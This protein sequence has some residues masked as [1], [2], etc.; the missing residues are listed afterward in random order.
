MEEKIKNDLKRF[1]R[2][3]LK[4]AIVFG[5]IISVLTLADSNG[6]IRKYLAGF[7]IVAMSL[8]GAMNVGDVG[9]NQ[10]TVLNLEEDLIKVVRV[11][12]GDTIVV[13]PD[14][15]VRLLGIDAPEIGECFYQESREI[16]TE[17]IQ[18]KEVILEKDISDKDIFGRLLR[19]IFLSDNK[20]FVNEYLLK[21][22]C[23]DVLPLDRNRIYRRL[24]TSGRNQ[25]ITERKG[26]WD[27]CEGKEKEA[28][29]IFPLETNDAPISSECLIK[30]NISE[31]GYG[32]TY[33]LPDDPTYKKVKISFNKGE[34]FFCTEEE[35][36]EAGYRKATTSY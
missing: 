29:T 15:H 8:S 25:A 17:L 1:S 36:E 19:Y 30:G 34:Q 35:A 13:E 28:E 23:A 7:F 18:D 10:E 2:V 5:A 26:M 3:F 22:G 9:S 11:I 21:E 33:F 12:D 6:T 14:V 32:R 24:L 4:I 31:H 20:L 16:L 27:A